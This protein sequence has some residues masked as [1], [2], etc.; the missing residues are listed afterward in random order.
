MGT[1]YLLDV[2]GGFGGVVEGDGGDEVVADVCA[3]DVVHEMGVDESEVTVDG[4]GGS[5]SEGPG[6]VVVVWH[7]SV[8][9]LEEGDCNCREKLVST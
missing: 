4:C 7:T 2:D 9:V 3:D 6:A 8:G 5:A 1:H